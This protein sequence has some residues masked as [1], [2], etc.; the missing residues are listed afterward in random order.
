MLGKEGELLTW[1]NWSPVVP[2]LVREP[3]YCKLFEST[4]F[5]YMYLVSLTCGNLLRVGCGQRVVGRMR[6]KGL[7]HE[8]IMGL[9]LFDLSGYKP[10]SSVYSPT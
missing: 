5:I 9:D 4:L 8:I 3:N 2:L 6:E 7:L 1:G 10:F